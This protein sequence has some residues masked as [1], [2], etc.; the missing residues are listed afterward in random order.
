M[1][2]YEITSTNYRHP[3][4]TGG[5]HTNGPATVWVK[6]QSVWLNTGSKSQHSVREQC[7]VLGAD[8]LEWL[9]DINRTIP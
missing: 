1:I 8:Y 4:D 6:Y 7:E 5:Q 3:D 2:E 9:Q